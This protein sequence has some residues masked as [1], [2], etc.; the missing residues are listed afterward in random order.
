MLFDLLAGYGGALRGGPEHE[1]LAV[2]VA[3]AA[4]AQAFQGGTV[5]GDAITAMRSNATA[6]AKIATIIGVIDHIAF[7]TNP[8]ARNAAVEAARAGGFAV[9]ANEVRALAS[10]SAHAAKEIK[11]LIADS[12]A[13]VAQGSQFVDTSGR[14]LGEIVTAVKKISAI[15]AAI[16]AA[17]SPRGSAKSPGRSC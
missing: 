7:Q 4:P 17:S 3:E 5:V 10:R 6:S 8:L 16:A 9:V 1:R 2:D 15:V 14:T 13:K 11:A 12:V